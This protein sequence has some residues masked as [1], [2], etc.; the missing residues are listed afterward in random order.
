MLK[1]DCILR[2]QEHYE[3]FKKKY[4]YNPK[5]V[6][7]LGELEADKGTREEYVKSLQE[8][9]ED[10]SR[11]DAS[12]RKPNDEMFSS[13]ESSDDDQFTSTNAHSPT[14]SS[15]FGDYFDS[16]EEYQALRNQKY[17]VHRTT[18]TNMSYWMCTA[19]FILLTLKFFMCRFCPWKRCLT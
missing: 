12:Q 19:R 6:S 15:G 4:A 1:V 13:S 8:C 11:N 7:A 2:F 16:D 5:F 17:E 14:S 10:I 3:L 18:F 9:M